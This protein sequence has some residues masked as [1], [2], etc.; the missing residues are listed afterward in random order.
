M[1]HEI[2]LLIKDRIYVNVLLCCQIELLTRY[3]QST[4][5][6][7]IIIDMTLSIIITIDMIVL[8]FLDKSILINTHYLLVI[9]S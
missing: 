1:T 5:E 3:S 8:N 4:L 9:R 2:K 6:L 7:Y